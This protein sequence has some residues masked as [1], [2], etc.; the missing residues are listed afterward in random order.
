MDVYAGS[1]R[2]SAEN[3]VKARELVNHTPAPVIRVSHGKREQEEDTMC[4][5][6]QRTLFALF[7]RLCVC[8]FYKTF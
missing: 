2:E 7:D 4:L 6:G 8:D 3:I 5:T 1:M